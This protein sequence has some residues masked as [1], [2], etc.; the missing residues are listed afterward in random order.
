MASHGA[1]AKDDWLFSFAMELL[2]VRPRVAYAAAEARARASSGTRMEDPTHNRR[3]GAGW[4]SKFG[5]RP[6]LTP[7]A[8]TISMC[9]GRAWASD[10]GWQSRPGAVDVCV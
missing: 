3:Q 4:T 2:R 6:D 10:A 9:R 8:A 7:W 5:G 1:W